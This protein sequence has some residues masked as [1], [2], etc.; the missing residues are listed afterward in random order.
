MKA[1]SQPTL[2]DVARVAGVGL[3]TA[4]R[5]V[6]SGVHVSASSQKKVEAA[7]RKLGYLPNHAARILKGGRTK[8]LGLLMPSLAD[9]FFARCAE[10]AEMVARSHDSLL[11]IAVSDNDPVLEMKNLAILMRHRPDGLL[12]VPSNATSRSLRQ[13][14]KASPVPIVTVDRPLPG[15]PAVLTNSFEAARAATQ[16]LIEHGRRRIVCLGAE[17]GLYTIQER[18]RGYT[19]AMNEAGLKPRIDMTLKLDGIAVE[20]LLQAQMKLAS[21]PDAIFSLK[22]SATVAVFQA[23]QRLKI[24][25]PADVALIGFDDFDLAET[26]RPALTVI[27][28]PV[29]DIGRCAAEI[30]FTKINGTAVVDTAPLLLSNTLVIRRSCGCKSR[31]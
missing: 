25:I 2:A 27:R 22:N 9:P 6:N 30:L 24:S 7:V 13:F 31:F 20:P 1:S 15:C 19:Q 5:V 17:P 14:A 26:L 18:L 29:E 3:A 12:I 21:P 28:Q 16:H 23:L 11:I 8:T 4:S 10:A